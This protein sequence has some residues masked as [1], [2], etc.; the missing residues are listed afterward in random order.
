[1]TEILLKL[2]NL[3]NLYN[4][5]ALDGVVHHLN[6]LTIPYSSLGNVNHSAFCVS[7]SIVLLLL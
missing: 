1:M 3:L 2:S 4:S 5:S 6:L 7:Q